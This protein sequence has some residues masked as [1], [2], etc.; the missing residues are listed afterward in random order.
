VSDLDKWA[1]PATTLA[2]T[3][4]VTHIY[5][6]QN[7][8]LTRFNGRELRPRAWGQILVAIPA[9]NNVPFKRS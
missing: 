8:G 2:A 9:G 6:G 1:A 3:H 4:T 5:Y 7:A